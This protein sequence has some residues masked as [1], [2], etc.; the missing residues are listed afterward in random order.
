MFH[1]AHDAS[2]AAGDKVVHFT[3]S[4]IETAEVLRSVLLLMTSS[5]LDHVQ[6]D[7]MEWCEHLANVVA[8][9]KKYECDRTLQA[10][11]HFYHYRY[12]SGDWVTRN[13]ALS[14]LVLGTLADDI[15]Y[16]TNVIA[17]YNMKLQ[18]PMGVFADAT[19]EVQKNEPRTHGRNAQP[20]NVLLP[21]NMSLTI[22]RLIPPDYIWALSRS[23][24][25]ANQSLGS[26][27]YEFS[28]F[29]HKTLRPKPTPAATRKAPATAC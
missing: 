11:L 17:I 16:C 14:G 19:A 20:T 2:N 29:A 5:E 10:L 27:A 4:T 28:S 21:A 13:H 15:I 3:D 9:L 1:A 23:W 8:F 6:R 12:L 18:T 24:L 22:H 7:T 26:W 25:V